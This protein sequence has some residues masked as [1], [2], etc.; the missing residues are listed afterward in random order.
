MESTGVLLLV[1]PSWFDYKSLAAVSQLSSLFGEYS[2]YLIERKVDAQ[3][4]YWP[5][6]PKYV[7]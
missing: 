2:D 7:R 1:D 4:H 3:C 5:K 6:G